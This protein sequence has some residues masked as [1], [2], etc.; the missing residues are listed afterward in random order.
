MRAD[1]SWWLSLFESSYTIE[2]SASHHRIRSHYAFFATDA[3]TSWGMGAFLGGKSF[4]MSWGRV[5]TEA[6]IQLLP[7]S[8]QTA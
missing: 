7:E 2:E 1:V 6:A 8:Q 4:K 3:R 5:G